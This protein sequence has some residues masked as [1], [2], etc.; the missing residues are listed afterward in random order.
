MACGARLGLGAQESLWCIQRLLC[1]SSSGSWLFLLSVSDEASSSR[2]FLSD[3][4]QNPPS[5]MFTRLA[6]VHMQI[7]VA[8]DRERFAS[9][10]RGKTLA[11]MHLNT[12]C[13]WLQEEDAACGVY[14]SH[15]VTMGGDT[16]HDLI[17]DVACDHHQTARN[18]FGATLFLGQS[19]H[20]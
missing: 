4:Y 8:D 12:Y 13:I 17:G 19:Y 6:Q 9:I 10:V 7:L 1:C 11:M 16:S 20:V 3:G 15:Q 2:C 14:S 5:V 18:R